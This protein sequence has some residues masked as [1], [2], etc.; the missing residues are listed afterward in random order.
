MLHFLVTIVI[1]NCTNIFVAD[2]RP[3]ACRLCSMEM[4]SKEM[5]RCH[6]LD[7][8][9][10]ES[11]DKYCETCNK[12]FICVKDLTLHIKTSGHPKP[13]L[14]A[15]SMATSPHTS[16]ATN[17]PK[18]KSVVK[19][20]EGEKPYCCPVCG[21][22]FERR[23]HLNRHQVVH[24]GD[25]PFACPLCNEKFSRKDG[26]KRHMDYKH[27]D[28]QRLECEIC[29]KKFSRSDKLKLH[30]QNMHKKTGL[31]NTKQVT[32]QQSVKVTQLSKSKQNFSKKKTQMTTD[33]NVETLLNSKCNR[34][35]ASVS[36]KSES[37]SIPKKRKHN[38]DELLFNNDMTSPSTTYV[39]ESF[40]VELKDLPQTIKQ[41]TVI[42][43][44]VSDNLRDTLDKPNADVTVEPRAIK[45]HPKMRAKKAMIQFS[46]SYSPFEFSRDE[47]T[48]Q[49][50]IQAQFG[51]TDQQSK[52]DDVK[53]ENGSHL[54]SSLNFST[55]P[56]SHVDTLSF[57][58]TLEPRDDTDPN[59]IKSIFGIL[60]SDETLADSLQMAS[61]ES[62]LPT[63]PTTTIESILCS[64]QPG[65]LA[66]SHAGIS[67]PRSVIAPI[68]AG[69][70]TTD[71]TTDIGSNI[72]K[73]RTLPSSDKPAQG[74]ELPP[75]GRS[76]TLPLLAMHDPG[77]MTHIKPAESWSD[78]LS[79]DGSDLNDTLQNIVQQLEADDS[80]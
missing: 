17:R 52:M 32:A 23:D 62:I 51:S 47:G 44:N 3:I 36:A 7:S 67:P 72:P 54:I 55:F 29:N 56:K 18:R 43:A 33:S 58:Q 19:H 66:G 6:L 27:G 37:S 8:H 24:T 28:T 57:P 2:I 38:F 65:S 79:D 12:M 60:P 50:S 75:G 31:K 5:Y 14:K 70:T 21:K 49:A 34:R 59:V 71:V 41:E 68:T 74:S 63:I 64:H 45:M 35:K 40:D 1:L 22:I 9:F 46:E 80:T 77:V 11:R 13:T 15:I 4:F 61:A 76:M 30:M 16:S 73:F 10:D 39:A 42:S 25:K 53:L 20:E 26:L 69:T 48:V 78:S